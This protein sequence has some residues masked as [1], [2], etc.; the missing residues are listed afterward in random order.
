MP[1]LSVKKA[2]PIAAKIALPRPIAQPAEIS[3]NPRREENFS[4]CMV[5]LLNGQALLPIVSRFPP[6]STQRRKP[7]PGR[8]GG[9]ARKKA[10]GRSF[11]RPDAGLPCGGYRGALFRAVTCPAGRSHRRSV[12]SARVRAINTSKGPAAERQRGKANTKIQT[13]KGK[14]RKETTKNRHGKAAAAAVRAKT[15]RG[16]KT[17]PKRSD[18]ASFWGRY[19]CVWLWG[20]AVFQPP[21]FTLWTAR[22]ERTRRNQ[23]NGFSVS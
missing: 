16:K 13:R 11:L 21:L 20:A 4:R 17:G 8:H 15:E 9:A 6:A 23:Q 3:R 7:F 14:H 5:T 19:V 12:T 2:C 18:P 10:G 1:R 22:A